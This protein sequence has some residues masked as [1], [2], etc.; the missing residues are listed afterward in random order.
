MAAPKAGAPSYG[1]VSSTLFAQLQNE[2]E[3]QICF[4]LFNEPVT[5]PCGHSYCRSCLARSYDHSDKC[6][7]CRT[8]LP[9]LS[10]FRW[11]RANRALT[12]VIEAALP[13]LAAERAAAVKEEELALLEHVPIF[14]C[15]SAWPGIK[16]YL[17]IFEPRYRLMIR[18][19]LE[20][21][22]KSFGMV[23]PVR[24]GGA[25]AVNEFGTMLRITSCQ[26]LDDGRLILETIG[27]HR[28]RLVER[29]V[30]DGY[31]VGK[32][33]RVDDVGARPPITGNQ[34]LTTHQLMQICL[35]FIKTLRAGSAP[36]VIERLNRTVGEIPTNAHDF[37][38]FAA[39]VFPVEDHVKVAL[40]QITSVRERLR[41]IVF[42]IEQI[43]SS[44]WYS[45]GC[46]IM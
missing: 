41:L 23:L 36:W 9:P 40:L 11:Q 22:D 46:T 35:D 45:R 3:C 34:E 24:N 12:A 21:P 38:W 28:F 18:R 5:A 4:Q 2:C 1:A 6:P 39:E 13:D 37:T 31:N 27:T 26:M 25:D 14:V 7:M 10:Y 29:S 30:V 15:T 8:S 20:T 17:H 42:W 16:S 33:E 44:W 19:A 32:I 43:R